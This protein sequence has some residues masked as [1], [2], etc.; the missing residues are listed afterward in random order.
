MS[1]ERG[2]LNP[3]LGPSEYKFVMGRLDTYYDALNDNPTLESVR[4]A[5]RRHLDMLDP[6]IKPG[7]S[8]GLIG[9]LEQRLS[10]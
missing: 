7:G 2:P 3:P 1:I 9:G 8:S 4:S 10:S 6:S 5:A